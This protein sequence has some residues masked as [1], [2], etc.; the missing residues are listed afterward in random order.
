MI[1]ITLVNVVMVETMMTVSVVTIITSY[2]KELVLPP[3][4]MVTTKTKPP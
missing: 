4:Q 3:V 1:V 2:I